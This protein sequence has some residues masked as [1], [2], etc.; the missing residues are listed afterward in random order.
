MNK[1]R[2]KWLVTAVFGL[3]MG[4]TAVYTILRIQA[5][6]APPHPYTTS[7]SFLVI[8]H[9]G[10]RSLG[11]ENTIYTFQRAVDMGVDVLE[12]DVRMTHD[13]QLVVI[14]DATVDRTS[15]GSGPVADYHLVG[16]R[17][18]DAGYRWSPDNGRSFPLRASGI[19]IPALSEVFEAFPRMRMN[20]ELKDHHPNGLASLCKLIQQY[21][22]TS[23]AMV[24]CFDADVLEKFRGQCPQVATSAGAAEVT[25][26]YF[27]QQMRLQAIYSPA[28]LALQVPVEYDAIRI[29]TKEF[30]DAA[31]QRNLQVHV[32]TVNDAADMRTLMGLGVDGIMT[33]HPQRLMAIKQ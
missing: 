3:L 4:L 24:A 14:H 22:M 25:T 9:R 20:I 1:H 11:P 28:A 2:T 10:G 19:R 12:M 31:H 32:W 7:D 5:Q 16:L 15:D 27:L 8:A 13:Q 18:L 17:A 29:V 21:D 23:Y 33:D 30:I 6:P 26:F